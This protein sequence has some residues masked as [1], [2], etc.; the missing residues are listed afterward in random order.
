MA[1]SRLYWVNPLSAAAP[2]HAQQFL[3]SWNVVEA[4]R[5][6]TFR[7]SP[8]CGHRSECVNSWFDCE[9]AQY[10]AV[11]PF[12]YLSS[13]LSVRATSGSFWLAD[14]FLS[15]SL[16]T[17]DSSW[18]C[19]RSFLGVPSLE[20]FKFSL[21]IG[22]NLVNVIHLSSSFSSGRSQASNVIPSR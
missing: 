17:T 14:L 16:I 22:Y 19:S 21:A 2:S 11:N 13:V 6:C 8:A 10:W 18:A 3:Y 1:L 5:W 4:S 20:N 9:L 15:T 7:S 12:P